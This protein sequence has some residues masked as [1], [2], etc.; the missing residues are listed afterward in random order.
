MAGQESAVQKCSVREV[1]T[2]VD[3]I[4]DYDRHYCGGLNE[5]FPLFFILYYTC[6]ILYKVIHVLFI[7]YN[8]I[9]DNYDDKHKFTY[10]YNQT[11][12]LSQ[13]PPVE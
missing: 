9:L 4:K 12:Q 7:S 6:T 3:P 10:T 8:T 13:H 1:E 11:A 2:N 5:V